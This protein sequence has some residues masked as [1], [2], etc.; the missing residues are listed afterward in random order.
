MADHHAAPVPTSAPTPAGVPERLEADLAL[1][2]RLADAA[3]ALSLDRFG[4]VDL[5]V[6]TKPD[7]TPVTDADRAVEQLLRDG[8][9]AERP[10]DALLGEEFGGGRD[11][12]ARRWILDPIDGTKNFV[13]GV[14]VWATLIALA[15]DGHPVVSVVSAPALARRWWAS[16]AGAFT[17]F[18]TDEP[19]P[20]HV[21]AVAALGDAS[22]SYSDAVGWPGQ[23]LTRL[24]GACWRT[25]AY[26]DFW[27]HMLVAEGAVDVAAE[28]DLAPWDVA[29]LVAVVERAGGTVSATT[30]GAALAGPGAVSTNGLLH[31]V[32]L[33]TLAASATD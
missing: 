9:A 1:A 32:V 23:G 12:V 17:R 29:A 30:G 18:A 10:A 14:P 7:M 22:L 24:A 6:D 11:D 20:L 3:D 26:G 16:P 2:L 27:S 5:V 25:R 19:R 8:L 15:V 28:P 33:A 4:A 31:D 21:S 13:R